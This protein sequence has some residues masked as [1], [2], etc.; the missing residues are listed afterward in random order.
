MKIAKHTYVSEA[1]RPMQKKIFKRI[2]AGK[3]IP[4]LYLITLPVWKSAML[5]IYS[6]S[7]LRG[8]F[9]DSTDMTIVAIAANEEDAIVI[10]QRLVDEMAKA[11]MLDRAKEYFC[12]ERN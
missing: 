3:S 12:G 4:S 2:E 8:D 5:E 7:E 11:D 6:Y 1:L 10:L 9:H